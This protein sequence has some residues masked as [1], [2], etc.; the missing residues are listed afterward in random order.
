MS[1]RRTAN[2]RMTGYPPSYVFA[3]SDARGKSTVLAKQQQRSCD[4]DRALQRIE[5][6]F[7]R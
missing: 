7:T 1:K 2:F 5:F 3:S 4:L 6:E